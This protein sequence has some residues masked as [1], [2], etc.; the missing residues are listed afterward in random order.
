VSLR[1][2]LLGPFRLWRDE[3]EITSALHKIG[4]A[5]TILKLL[6]SQWG[7]TFTTDQ[8]VETLWGP[9]LEDHKTTLE[10][11][12]ANLHR[13]LSELRKLLEPS[14][15]KSSESQYVLSTSKGYSFNPKSACRIDVDEFA[16]QQENARVL[17]TQKQFEPAI[18]AYESALLLLHGDYLAEDRYAEWAEH[19]RQKWQEF[20]LEALA[21]LAECHARLGQYRRAIARCHQA[22]R[23][24]A[25]RESL[26]RQLMLYSYL[27]GDQAEALKIYEQCRDVLSNQLGVAPSLETK[28]LYEQIL[29]RHLPGIDQIYTPLAMERHPIPYSLGRTPFVGRTKEISIAANRLQQAASG[30]GHALFVFGEAGIGKT[31][32]VQELL[33]LARPHQALILQGR[34]S[35]LVV[36]LAFEPIIQA[37]RS[38]FSQISER[39][40]QGVAALWLAEIAK[41][42]P[43]FLTLKTLPTNP[44]LAPEQERHRLFEALTQLLLVL[45]HERLLVLCLDDLHWSDSATLDFLQ[46]LAPRIAG[47]PIVLLGTYRHDELPRPPLAPL[48]DETGRDIVD[49]VQLAR[50]TL[51]ETQALLEHM[52][53]VSPLIAERLGRRLHQETE[54]NPFFLVAVLQELFE[55]GSMRV[56]EEGVW[57]T[58]IDAI[59][60]NY[61]ELSIPTKVKEIII[62]RLGR[63]NEEEK[64]LLTLA[65]VAGRRFDYRLLE[66][67][68][69]QPGVLTLIERLEKSQLIVAENGHY[70][71]NHDKVREVLYAETSPPRRQQMHHQVAETIEELYP[72]RLAEHYNAL[73]Y[74]FSQCQHTAKAFEYTLL[75]LRQA[76]ARYQNE[77]GLKLTALGLTLSHTLKL[78]K[79]LITSEFTKQVFEVLALRVKLF[80]IV[81]QRAEQA[82]AIDAAFRWAEGIQSES[83]I[84]DAKLMKARLA[85]ALGKYAEAQ[86]E[87]RAAIELAQKLNDRQLEARALQSLGTAHWHVGEHPQALDCYTR[88]STLAEEIANRTEATN[89]L[90]NIGIVYHHLGRYEQALE[91][92]R[93]ACDVA[94]ATGD[95]VVEASA[96]RNIGAVRQ[97]L[98]EYA[99]AL[100]TYEQS[101]ELSNSIGD[102]RGQTVSLDNLGSLSLRLGRYD[103]A[104]KHYEKAQAFCKNI[105]D[106]AKEG[107]VLLGLGDIYEALGVPQKALEYFQKA[108][109]ISQH[110]GNRVWEAIALHSLG[111]AHQGLGEYPLALRYYEEAR[112]LQI[113]IGDKLRESY[114]LYALGTL[115]LARSQYPEALQWFEQA[116]HM[117]EELRIKPLESQCMTQQSLVYLEQKEFSKALQLSQQALALLEQTQAM[118]QTH[119]AHFTHYRILMVNAKEPEAHSFLHKAYQGVMRLAENLEDLEMRMLFLKV[120]PNPDI[121]TLW[122]K[123]QARTKN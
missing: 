39:A 67:A 113:K 60:T 24:Q 52:G 62:K 29:D 101:Y 41:L 100:Q 115:C 76:V 81:G 9:E 71:F 96:L 66:K 6:L 73:S 112:A 87:A 106:R 38:S 50:L 8:L 105:R 97:H 13:R 122:E 43:E 19:S 5:D 63:L 118:P 40:T 70:E 93:R 15:K 110:L 21:N 91:C 1:I 49:Y 103:K 36:K 2:Q 75:A 107:Q 11:A 65:S 46:Y 68:S 59:T 37:L 10:K 22:L 86:T 98:G 89:A 56:N 64:E 84:A 27:S 116:R 99:T 85:I 72:A 42:V 90:H 34:C 82:T 111:E 47:A 74:H 92:Y 95:K 28:T 88:A 20:F 57:T 44:T 23:V 78:E 55:E 26:Y 117:A 108:Y 53:K 16:H 120:S 79:S 109:A 80:E 51:L 7:Q 17:Q 33:A 114:S 45:S 30:Q 18:V 35:D 31:R 32:F 48:R 58:D 14:L 102:A 119:R 69:G 121:L 54:G 4:K 83:F 3:E 77:E 104:L 123:F 12:T 94:H 61:K 25:H